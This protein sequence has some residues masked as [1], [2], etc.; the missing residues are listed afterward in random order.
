MGR[1]WEQWN[2]G[3]GAFFIELA[4]MDRGDRPEDKEHLDRYCRECTVAHEKAGHEKVPKWNSIN[5]I[6]G[7]H[8]EVRSRIGFEARNPES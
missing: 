5:H 2:D 3:M 1:W 8:I 4:Y 7:P 6:Q